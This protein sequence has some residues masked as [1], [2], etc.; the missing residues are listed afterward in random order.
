MSSKTGSDVQ[1]ERQVTVRLHDNLC[2]LHYECLLHYKLTDDAVAGRLV[3]FPGCGDLVL[4][5]GLGRPSAAR[6]G[7]SSARATGAPGIRIDA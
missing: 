4:A 1:S 2:L 7:P 3:S 5:R 6:T